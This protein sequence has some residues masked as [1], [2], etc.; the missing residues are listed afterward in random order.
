MPANSKLPELELVRAEASRV[1]DF[2]RNPRDPN[3]VAI[4]GSHEKMMQINLALTYSLDFPN[5][6]KYAIHCNPDKVPKDI[7]HECIWAGERFIWGVEASSVEQLR[8]A[9]VLPTDGNQG[10]RLLL[11]QATRANLIN[12]CL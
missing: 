6:V 9:G 10:H 2:I 5:L 11:M 12:H 4:L 7:L 8:F 1:Q 3:C